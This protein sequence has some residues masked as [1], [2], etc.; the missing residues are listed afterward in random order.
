MTLQKRTQSV[1]RGNSLNKPNIRFWIYFTIIVT[2]ILLS[3]GMP[4]FASLGDYEIQDLYI[5]I[6]ENVQEA[7]ILLQKAFQFAQ[8]SP[9]DVINSITE[10]AQGKVMI[11]IRIASKGVALVVAALLLMVEFFRKSINFEWSSKW[12][13]IL[14]FLVK[15]IVIKQ[16]VQ[17]AD[18]IVAYIYAGFQSINDAATGGTATVSFLPCGDIKRYVMSVPYR[19]DKV[20]EWVYSLVWHENLADTYYI[21]ADAVKMF[22]PEAIFPDEGTYSAGVFPFTSPTDKSN[23]VP[24]IEYLLFQPYFFALKCIAIVI[25]VITIGRVFELAIYTIFAPLPLVTFA[26]DTTHDVAKNFI[27]NYIATV[28]QIAVIVIMFM[29]YVALNN[30]IST[31]STIGFGNVKLLQYVTLGTLGLGVIKSGTWARKVCG[32]G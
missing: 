9:Y 30:Y 27:K 19:G 12:E 14:I 18:T 26:S 5:A 32:I 10:T 2:M 24:L 31:E 20:Y 21:S 23:F 15:L 6:T 1:F 16:V 25:F 7:N 4:V 11:D 28:L 8:I 3:N 22:Y 17:N 29:V 13:N